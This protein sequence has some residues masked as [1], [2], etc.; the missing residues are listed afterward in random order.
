VRL[1]TLV[2]H[3]SA[4]WPHSAGRDF[5]R[6]LTPEGESEAAAMGQKL[7]R[8][9]FAPDRLL[10][11]S[12]ERAHRTC[13]ILAAEIGFPHPRIELL[14]RLYGASLQEL[15]TVVRATDAGCRHLM[16]VAHNPGIGEFAH[17][18]GARRPSGMPTCAVGRF[19]LAVESWD[20]VEI[21]CA[22]LLSFDRPGDDGS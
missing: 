1:L 20:E 13:E 6:P 11:S 9:G 2:R 12:A 7:S 17:R 21:G 10:C 8:E 14:D 19:E 3:A 22:A 16:L 4:G 15:L 5:D 18:L